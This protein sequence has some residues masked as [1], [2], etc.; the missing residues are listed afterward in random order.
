MKNCTFHE[1]ADALSNAADEV[2]KI[3]GGENSG[4][5][6]QDLKAATN[7]IEAAIGML[8]RLLD[9]AGMDWE[10]LRTPGIHRELAN[11]LAHEQ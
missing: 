8:D 5:K 11:Q 4:L 2:G 1:A 9:E 3:I 7:M 6:G 10:N